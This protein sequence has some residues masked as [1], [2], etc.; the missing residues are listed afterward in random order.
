MIAMIREIVVELIKLKANRFFWIYLVAAPALTLCVAFMIANGI[1]I[2]DTSTLAAKPWPIWRTTTSMLFSIQLAIF[3]TFSGMFVIS[4][5][6]QEHD[7]NTFKVYQLAPINIGF[8]LQTRFC[9]HYILYS[10]LFIATGIAGVLTLENIFL[11]R[12]PESGEAGLRLGTYVSQY[13]F[14]SFKGILILGL[15]LHLFFY[16]LS[17]QLRKASIAVVAYAILVVSS[18]L[19]LSHWY[20]PVLTSTGLRM[21]RNIYHDNALYTNSDLNRL[22]IISIGYCLAILIAYYYLIYNNKLFTKTY[23]KV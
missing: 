2:Q 6:Q 13:I 4:W 19:N 18:F 11:A 10:I 14:V 17:F 1:T 20:F 12:F 7:D 23:G 8:T 9:I 22:Y 5:Q 16:I 3:Y 15:P 21:I